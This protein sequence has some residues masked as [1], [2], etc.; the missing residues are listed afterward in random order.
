MTWPSIEL[1]VTDTLE[2]DLVEVDARD[3]QSRDR[4]AS[5][6]WLRH[7]ADNSGCP[8]ARGGNGRVRLLFFPLPTC[9]IRAQRAADVPHTRVSHER[10][11]GDAKTRRRRA[12]DAI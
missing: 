12:H 4:R 3:Q 6:D 1:L 9:Q 7:G 11:A 8:L 5:S 10:H 2:N